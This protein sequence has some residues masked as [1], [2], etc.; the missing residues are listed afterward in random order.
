M[1]KKPR[2]KRWKTTHLTSGSYELWLRC[3]NLHSSCGHHVM[4]EGGFAVGFSNIGRETVAECLRCGA[5]FT[6]RD[7]TIEKRTS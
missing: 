2:I 5:T 1:T 6:E 4:I 3:K 7:G